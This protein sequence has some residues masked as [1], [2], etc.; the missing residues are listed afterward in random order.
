MKFAPIGDRIIV[1]RDTPD[2]KSAG[3]ILL[4]ESV[5]VKPLSGTVIAVGTGGLTEM[6]NPKPMPF[7]AGQRVVF[8]KYAGVELKLD[9]KDVTI[10]RVDDVLCIVE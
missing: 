2:T 5:Q 7:V 9:G 1:T 8:G 3:G 6:G 4:P 10:L